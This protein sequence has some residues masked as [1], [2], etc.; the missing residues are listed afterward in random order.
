MGDFQHCL[1]TLLYSISIFLQWAY[2]TFKIREICFFNEY[3]VKF[4][5]KFAKNAKIKLF[6]NDP[7]C[8]KILL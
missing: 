1:Y 5:Y 2:I 6:S 4:N 7:F 8:D 3:L